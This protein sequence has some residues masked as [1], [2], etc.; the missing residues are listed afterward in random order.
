[1]KEQL[2][3]KILRVAGRIELLTSETPWVGLLPSVTFQYG[4]AHLSVTFN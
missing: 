2:T 1:M 3:E 4:F